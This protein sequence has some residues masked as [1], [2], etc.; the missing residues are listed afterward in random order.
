MKKLASRQM[1]TAFGET[2]RFTLYRNGTLYDVHIQ[3]DLELQILTL[4]PSE[5]KSLKELLNSLEVEE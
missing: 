4:H 2:V 1:K 5:I 3:S